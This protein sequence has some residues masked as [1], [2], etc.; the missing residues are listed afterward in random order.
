MTVKA[1][2]PVDVKKQYPHLD[3]V[4]DWRARQTIRLLWD[5]LYEVLGRV[6]GVETTAKDLVEASNAQDTKLTQAHQ[7]ADEA[8]AT[9]EYTKSE[10]QRI[11]V[12]SHLPPEAPNRMA[13]LNA[14]LAAGT[15]VG[16]T[17]WNLTVLY[18]ATG[19]SKFIEAVVDDC[20]TTDVR[21]GHI[22]KTGGQTGS[23]ASGGDGHAVD[24]MAWKN[25]DGVTAE[26]YDVIT[27]TGTLQW[28][29]DIG[30]RDSGYALSLWKYPP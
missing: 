5:Q 12:K 26:I 21:W 22:S 27:S 16:G 1:S 2:K 29:Y 24:S 23:V 7:K 15:P 14:R 18:G 20:R 9:A 19:Q 10:Q 4:E 30:S 25:T 17:P 13:T 11:A 8:L 3:G 28:L 6:Q